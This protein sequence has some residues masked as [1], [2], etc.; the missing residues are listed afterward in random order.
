MRHWA[1]EVAKGY[2][3][4][5]GYAVL[6]ENYTVRGAEIDLVAAQD[7]LTVIVEVR[8]RRSGRYGT[9]A[10]TLT[11]RKLERLQI[12]AL[13]FISER[14]GRDDLPLRFDAILVSGNAEAHTLEHLEGI[15]S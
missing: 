13:H 10:E 15:V 1:E 9:P 6:A 12:A 5:R 2:L 14:F 8:Q 7:D 4:T 3:E 11:P